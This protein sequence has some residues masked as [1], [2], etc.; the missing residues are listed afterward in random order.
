MLAAAELK[1][2]LQMPTFLALTPQ[3]Q[4]I[5]F[6]IAEAR[7]SGRLPRD[8][9]GVEQRDGRLQISAPEEISVE[10]DIQDLFPIKEAG[11]LSV[12]EIH[13]TNL[14]GSPTIDWAVAL[15]GSRDRSGQLLISDQRPKTCASSFTRQRSSAGL[16]ARSP[17]PS[18][19][20]SA[21]VSLTASRSW[22]G[23]SPADSDK[24]LNRTSTAGVPTIRC[25]VR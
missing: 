17:A 11:Y 18:L 15:T 7:E 10:G 6:T 4:R 19:D 2:H 22:D 25:S 14:R 9:F 23:G 5:L 1:R 20:G 21:S 13:S 12:R 16:P 24:S 8:S 3:Q